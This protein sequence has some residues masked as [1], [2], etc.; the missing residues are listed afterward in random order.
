MVWK[1]QFPTL[2]DSGNKIDAGAWLA[3]YLQLSSKKGPIGQQNLDFIKPPD[4]P[5]TTSLSVTY[6]KG[7]YNIAAASESSGKEG[8]VPLGGTSFYCQIQRPGNGQSPLWKRSLLLSYRVTF[9]PEFDFVKGGKLPGLYSG[10]LQSN[11]KIFKGCQGGSREEAGSKCWSVRIMWRT[12]GAGEGVSR[13]KR[14]HVLSYLL[15]L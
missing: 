2:L 8:S 3:D 6:P 4:S 12:E 10:L 1:W 11:G 14:Q 15:R 13:S 9:S 5:P 7:S